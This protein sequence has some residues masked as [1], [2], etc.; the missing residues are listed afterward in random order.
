MNPNVPVESILAALSNKKRLEMLNYIYKEKFLIK[1]ELIT[2]FNLQRAGLDFHLSALEDAGLIGS[3]EMK[4][5][6]RKYVFIYPKATWKIDLDPVETTSLQALLPSEMSE[7]EFHELAESFWT[8]A[9]EI[10]D[11]QTIKKVLESLASRLG[12][13]SSDYFCKRCGNGIGI[14][15]CRQCLELYCNECTKIIKKRD[16]SIIMLCYECIADQFS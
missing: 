2:H 1:N 4:I 15:K 9:N 3:S 7:T 12:S 8:E 11:P 14:V 5:K 16:G 13:E 10:K 6:G